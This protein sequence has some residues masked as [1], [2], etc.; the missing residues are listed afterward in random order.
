M[1]ERA[2]MMGPSVP[3]GTLATL[4]ISIYVAVNVLNELPVEPQSYFV[5]GIAFGSLVAG[6]VLYFS[7]T[8]LTGVSLNG[9]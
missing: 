7:V 4:L 1:S 2:Q 5:L 8:E 9:D 3:L 6:V